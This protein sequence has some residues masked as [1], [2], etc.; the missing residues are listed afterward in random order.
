MRTI[1]VVAIGAIF[2]QLSVSFASDVQEANEIEEEIPQEENNVKAMTFLLMLKAMKK[3]Q[4]AHAEKLRSG[5]TAAALEDSKLFQQQLQSFK[6]ILINPENDV[7]ENMRQRLL[8]M[9]RGIEVF[10]NKTFGN[11]CLF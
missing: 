2:L 9:L 6:E 7:D 1:I 8:R 5:D 11:V 4:Q 10:I 3:L